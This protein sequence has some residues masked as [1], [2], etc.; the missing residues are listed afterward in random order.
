MMSARRL[1][2]L[3]TAG[4]ASLAVA[5]AAQADYAPARATTGGEGTGPGQFGTG[6][7][8]VGGERQYNSPG[9]SVFVKNRLY[10]SDTSNNRIM[11]FSGNFG[12]LRAFGRFVFDPGSTTPLRNQGFILP[13]GIAAASNG[14]LFIADNRN[15]RVVQYSPTGRFIRRLGRRGSIG[16]GMVSPWGIAV[17][18]P[19]VYVVDQGNF[20]IKIFSTS[21]G[22]MIKRFGQFGTDPENGEL[23]APYGIAVTRNRIFVSDTAVDKILVFTTTGR[24]VSTIGEKG[25]GPGEFNQPAGLTID[26]A[27]KLLVAD[28]ANQRIQRLNANGSFF[29][30][31]GEG[32]LIDPTFV[33]TDPKGR[34]FV[35]DFRNV[36]RF[37]PTK[38]VIP[39]GE[40]PQRPARLACVS[41]AQGVDAEPEIS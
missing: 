2:L 3:L 34:V 11:S 24:F 40:P 28:C 27:G 26:P 35:S 37:D 1:S 23:R 32:F 14:S 30:S 31:F 36:I 5:P 4:L 17:L 19:R 41:Q 29:E 12:F 38:T 33:S 16:D 22:R 13:Q 25:S 7:E 15:D 21:T 6:R 8:A 39:K 10:V 20:Q 9:G 18:G